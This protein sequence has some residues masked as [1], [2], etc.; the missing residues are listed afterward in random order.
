MSEQVTY[1]Q[2]NDIYEEVLQNAPLPNI[3]RPEHVEIVEEILSID[4]EEIWPE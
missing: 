4:P 3:V 2:L 1:E